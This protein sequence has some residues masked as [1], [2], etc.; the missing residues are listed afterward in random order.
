MVLSLFSMVAEISPS[1]RESQQAIETA[2]K[3]ILDEEFSFKNFSNEK[4][5]LSALSEAVAESKI[6]VLCAEPGIYKAFGTF[7]AN[8]FNLKMRANK[9]ISKAIIS[10]HPE[11]DDDTVSVHATIPVGAFPLVS[12]DGLYSGYGIKAKK[13]L[14][15][16]LPLDDKRID[17][18]IN[19]GLYPFVRAN[20]DFSVLNTADPLKDVKAPR[21]TKTAKSS[22][23]S[24]MYDVQVIKEAVKKL[25][26]K[27]LSVA[28]ANTKTVDFLG[29]ISTSA[30]DLSEI[31]FI[32]DY[33]CEKGDMSARE[34]AI[35]LANGAL[36]NSSNSVGAAITKV[37]SIQ[38]EDGTTQYFMY[39]CIADKE[40]ANVAK[41]IAEP[42][43][44]P[45][46]LI[47]KAVEE[48][49]KMLSLWSDTGYAMPQ[50]TDEK[51]VKKTIEA[52]EADEKIQK[53]KIAVSA[54][55][56]G[57]TVAA[58][59]ISVFVQNVYGVL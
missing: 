51:V 49:F 37:F 19:A 32:S 36:I 31:V 10:S 55:V 43:D 42:D 44:T 48:L 52:Y 3:T 45:P 4:M 50:F 18:I 11:L 59:L 56:A 21:L 47:Y 23:N 33:T 5:F 26:S 16:V 28:V 41:L 35:N 34:Y 38:N 2:F 9:T 57:A 27:G 25:S 20:M 30:V 17:Y 24:S 58:T 13:Q 53:M 39:V 40:N 29:N 12:E 15:I 22:G 46:M 14:L 6:V 1:A 54:I 7:V 8:A